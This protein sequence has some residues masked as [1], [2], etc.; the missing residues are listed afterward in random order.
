[1]LRG[2]E[3]CNKE[4]GGGQGYKG[5]SGYKGGRRGYAG[6]GRE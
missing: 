6:L 3:V 4:K 5:R 2:K 1:M